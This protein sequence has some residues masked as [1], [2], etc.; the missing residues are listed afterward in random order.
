M[1]S[2]NAAIKSEGGKL[3]VKDIFKN[4]DSEA[5]KITDD[6]INSGSIADNI[7]R[8][9]SIMKSGT[10]FKIDKETENLD[11]VILAFSPLDRTIF[12]IQVKCSQ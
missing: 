4:G 2:I 5:E 6:I 7:N 9:S 1:E 3:N 12:N 8:Y 11:I 10:S